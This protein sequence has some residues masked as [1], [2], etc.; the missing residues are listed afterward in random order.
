M[1]ERFGL[2]VPRYES[3]K[4]LGAHPDDVTVIAADSD[5][6]CWNSPTVSTSAVSG[7]NLRT[8]YRRGPSPA[9]RDVNCSDVTK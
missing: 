9:L 6:Y 7:S 4:L 2:W 3:G 8:V 1:F 5:P